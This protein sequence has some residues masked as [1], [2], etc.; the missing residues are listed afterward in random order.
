MVYEKV[1]GLLHYPTAVAAPS[2]QFQCDTAQLP[3]IKGSNHRTLCIKKLSLYVCLS[4]T[5]AHTAHVF[6]RT[7]LSTIHIHGHLCIIHK[8]TCRLVLLYKCIYETQYLYLLLVAASNHVCATRG[9]DDEECAV[10]LSV[11][12]F[13]SASMKNHM[14][15]TC[16]THRSASTVAPAY[17]PRIPSLR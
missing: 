10:Y 12:L 6:T 3:Y 8:H 15:T 2:G 14:R 4:H 5:H 16:G 7:Y 1:T 11:R 9:H 17:H 13:C